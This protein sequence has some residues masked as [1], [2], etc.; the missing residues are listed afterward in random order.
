MDRLT[1]ARDRMTAAFMEAIEHVGLQ[2]S[3]VSL[4]LEATREFREA[5]A[6]HRGGPR[7]SHEGLRRGVEE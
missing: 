2:D 7:V 4:E 1:V 6:Q 3:R 5:F